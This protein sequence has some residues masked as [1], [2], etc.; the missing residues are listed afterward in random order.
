MINHT[1]FYLLFILLLTMGSCSK[2]TSMEDEGYLLRVRFVPMVNGFPMQPGV[3]HVSSMGET[4]RADV[5][6]IYVGNFALMDEGSSPVADVPDDYYL[7]DV[8]DSASLLV[9]IHGN[10]TP[11]RGLSM[12]I[13]IDSIRNVSGAQ[14]GEL[15]PVQGMFW[16]W[17]TGYIHAKFEGSS[18]AS[19]RPDKRFTY[20]IGG[21]REKED[22]KRVIQLELPIQNTWAL[23]RSG[24]SEIT[25]HMD[26]DAW[27]RS[28]HELPIAAQAQIMQPG[29]LAV[30][31]ADNYARMF[32]LES[33]ERR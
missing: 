4:F 33:I 1:R 15:D 3:D 29:P 22:T 26:I 12:Q 20:H 9:D 23:E 32:S 16:T 19:T 8:Y 27:F 2:E 13:G 14:T 17:S 11:F 24:R 28:V 7:L 5:F 6:R 21:F 18:P 25:I 31:Y 10:G 30:R